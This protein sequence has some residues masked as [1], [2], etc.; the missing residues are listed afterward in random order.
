MRAWI[1]RLVLLTCFA[2]GALAMAAPALAQAPTAEQNEFAKTLQDRNWELS[3]ADR[4][5]TCQLKFK[6][7]A[8][9]AGLGLEQ[10]PDCEALAFMKDVVAWR[11]RG[12]DGI[13]LIDAG[14]RTV[15]E[16]SEVENSI[17]EGQRVGEG[18]FLL[19]NSAEAQEAERSM[20]FLIGNW[21]LVRQ[22][23]EPVC[24]LTLTNTPAEADNFQIFTKPPCNPPVSTFAPAMWRLERGA[25]LMQSAG[26]EIWR[27]EADDLAQWR[28]VP[29]EASPLIL[30]RR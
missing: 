10:S 22:Q 14:G 29:E 1:C 28:R 7:D 13:N 21:A 17:F 15:I 19:Q 18:I 4:S 11:V 24:R 6:T 30:Q 23:G 8:V 12:L 27:F 5:R 2:V 26:G 3:S 20:D 16:L 9:P 25:I